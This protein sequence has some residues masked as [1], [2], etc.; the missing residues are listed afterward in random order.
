MAIVRMSVPFAHFPCALSFGTWKFLFRIRKNGAPRRGG[1][2]G[3][4]TGDAESGGHADEDVDRI[5]R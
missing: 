3:A 4:R 1:R 2:G 5:L